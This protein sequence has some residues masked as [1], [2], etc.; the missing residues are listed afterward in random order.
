MTVL[1]IKRLLLELMLVLFGLFCG[2]LICEVV[3]RIRRPDLRNVVDSKFQK[4]SYRIHANPKND[5]YTRVH[6]CMT[7]TCKDGHSKD[8]QSKVVLRS[9]SL[10]CFF[11]QFCEQERGS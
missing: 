3:L 8:K 9:A 10:N 6:P 5:V 1:Q 11:E 4:H 7:C 2:F